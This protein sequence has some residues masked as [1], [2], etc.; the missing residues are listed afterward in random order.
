MI[1]GHHTPIATIEKNISRHHTWSKGKDDRKNPRKGKD[2]P[3][4]QVSIFGGEPLPCHFTTYA[5]SNKNQHESQ[6]EQYQQQVSISIPGC[7]QQGTA[8]KLKYWEMIQA[9]DEERSP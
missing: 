9:L 7:G 1:H 3:E 2:R 5:S 4:K 6:S 8:A